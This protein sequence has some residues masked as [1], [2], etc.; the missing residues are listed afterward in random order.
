MYLNV[1]VA[2]PPVG[3]GISHKSIKGTK[4]V[5]YEHGRRYD[6]K[7]GYTVPQTTSIGKICEEDDSVMY[8]NANYLKFFPEAELSEELPL[9]VRSGCLN[10]D[11][12]RGKMDVATRLERQEKKILKMS[13]DLERA[14]EDYKLLQEEKKKDDIKK[15]TP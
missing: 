3:N 13:E 5:Y 15:I 6:S 1:T 4:Y 12:A 14:K 10:K 11:M 2:T 8:P 7:R 9:S